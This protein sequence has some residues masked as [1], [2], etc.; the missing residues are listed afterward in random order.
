[1]LCINASKNFGIVLAR[2]YSYLL[3]THTTFKSCDATY[4]QT[5]NN[6]NDNLTKNI[7]CGVVGAEINLNRNLFIY[8]RYTIDFKKNN[9]DGTSSNPS[10]KNQVF[11]FGLGVLL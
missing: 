5:V 6:E 1:L 4:E 10:Y 7:F 8:G 11:R 2:Q 3:S 9:G